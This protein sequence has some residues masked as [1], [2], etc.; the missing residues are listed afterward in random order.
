L[1]DVIFFFLWVAQFSAM[2]KIDDPAFG[3]LGIL[4]LFD[5]SGIVITVK[6]L[7]VHLHTTGIG[8][9]Y[10][11]FDP[12]LPALALSDD[13]WSRDIVLARIASAGIA[14]LIL[15]PSFLFFHRYSTDKV[16]VSHT[17]SRRSPMEI[18]N[19]LTRPLTQLV[20]PIFGLAG[21]THGLV[22]LAL[23]DVALTLCSA[24]AA[25]LVLILIS[26]CALFVKAAFLP[27][28]LIASIAFWGI[29][30]SDVSTRDF[31]NGCE[32][33]TG[34]VSGGIRQRY[35]RQ[36]SATFLL[37][38]LFSGVIALR[39]LFQHPFQVC[40]MLVGVLSLSAL[41]SLFGRTARTSRLFLSLFLFWLYVASQVHNSAVIDIVAF[42]GAA[43][44]ISTLIQLCIAFIALVSG[45]SYNRWARN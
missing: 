35:L 45:Y 40:S 31:F 26:T 10:A 32:E 44:V 19:Q 21:R 2:S 15:L 12:K 18:L 27:G 42:N 36:F 6:S 39:L 30:V 5:F 3:A 4:L 28:L 29:I 7:Y 17:R 22:G 37:G 25:I 23:A 13:L 20:Q 1:G 9:G 34:V 16:K 43:N 24:P 38:M 33:L 8:I 11:T 41:S 14:S